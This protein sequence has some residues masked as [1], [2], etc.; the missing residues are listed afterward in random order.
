M[1]KV[2]GSDPT[3]ASSGGSFLGTGKVRGLMR[4]ALKACRTIPDHKKVDVTFHVL[5][6]TFASLAAQNGVTMFELQKI[7]GHKTPAMTSRYSHFYPEAARAA[8]NRL[9]K[10][11][12]RKDDKKRHRRSGS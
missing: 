3:F 5:R 6:H 4:R 12:T 9:G 2:D 8:V 1:L 7:L 11:L 10:I